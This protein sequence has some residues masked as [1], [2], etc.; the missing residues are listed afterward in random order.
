MGTIVL[1]VEVLAA[2]I[3]WIWSLRSEGKGFENESK[4]KIGKKKKDGEEELP[5]WDPAEQPEYFAGQG[6]QQ[7]YPAQQQ[8]GQYGSYP[9]QQGGN[10]PPQGN[11]GGGGWSGY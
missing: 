3:I 1:V 11:Q 8:S 5:Q 2:W 10:Y 4:P 7:G 6:R 9:P